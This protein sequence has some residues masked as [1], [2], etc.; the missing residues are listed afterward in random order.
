MNDANLLAGVTLRVGCDTRPEDPSPF[1]DWVSLHFAAG[2][3]VEWM[4]YVGHGHN[5]TDQAAGRAGGC[6]LAVAPQ[7]VEISVCG[8]VHGMA[9]IRQLEAAARSLRN[10]YG[11]YLV[12]TG[13]VVPST[14][15][16][17]CA[18]DRAS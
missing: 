1:R 17:D 2:P 15:P 11:P 9:L 10:H 16:I 3:T 8:R 7:R 18:V 4:S 6:D 5:G 13:D 12:D 14:A